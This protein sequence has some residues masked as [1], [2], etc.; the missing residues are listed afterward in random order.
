LDLQGQV[1]GNTHRFTD[2]ASIRQQSQE[3][4][5][6]FIYNFS[7]VKR[8]DRNSLRFEGLVRQ[9]ADPISKSATSSAKMFGICSTLQQSGWMLYENTGDNPSLL[10]SKSS[11][12][13]SAG[14]GGAELC[15]RIDPATARP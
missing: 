5:P 15:G 7:S 8:S 6:F 12:H 13:S 3:F 10:R 2:E 4:N 9:K 11:Y 1:S 14:L